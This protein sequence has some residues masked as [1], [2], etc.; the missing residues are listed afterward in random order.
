MGDEEIEDRQGIDGPG[1]VL[2][3]T[4]PQRKLVHDTDGGGEVG[5]LLQHLAP[6]SAKPVQQRIDPGRLVLL[7]D[8]KRQRVG[9]ILVVAQI[10]QQLAAAVLDGGELTN[11]S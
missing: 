6:G 3:E 11:E 8:E 5:V 10:A 4:T 7:L 1:D 2:V 9:E